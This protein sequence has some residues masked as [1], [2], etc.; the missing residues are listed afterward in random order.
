MHH[1]LLGKDSPT[2][3]QQVSMQ[4]VFKTIGVDKT[5]KHSRE[6]TCYGNRGMWDNL[7]GDK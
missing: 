5:S 7:D 2:G 1:V 3:V 6:E 4:A